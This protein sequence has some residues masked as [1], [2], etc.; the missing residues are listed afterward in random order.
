MA[1]YN[2]RHNNLDNRTNWKPRSFKGADGKYYSWSNILPPGV[3]NWVAGWINVLDNFDSLGEANYENLG[4]KFS[5]ILSASL[6]DDAGLSVI[7]PH[8]SNLEW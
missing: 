1:S 8:R 2:D 6:A 4:R 3:E 5:F 7:E